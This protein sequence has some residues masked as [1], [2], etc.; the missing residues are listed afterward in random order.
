MGASSAGCSL[1][2]LSRW[3]AGAFRARS[4]QVFQVLFAKEKAIE[5]NLRP[6]EIPNAYSS[7]GRLPNESIPVR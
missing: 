2:A 7:A 5:G 1:A 6:T 3:D 4:L